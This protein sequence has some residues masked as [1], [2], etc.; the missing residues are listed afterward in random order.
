MDDIG[1][2]IKDYGINVLQPSPAASMKEMA[3]QIAERD[4]AVRN[5]ALNALTE[6][7]FQVITL[8]ELKVPLW[9]KSSFDNC[10]ISTS[11]IV[12]KILTFL[13]LLFPGG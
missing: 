10:A 11:I 8:K 9:A 13:F 7:F 12:S 5:A 2:M 3:K 1:S 4:T 6:A